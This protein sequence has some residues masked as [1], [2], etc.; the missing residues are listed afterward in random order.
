[1]SRLQ[2]HRDSIP[3][4]QQVIRR[5]L[6]GPLLLP[7][8]WRR[9]SCQDQHQRQSA[10]NGIPLDRLQ[11]IYS[12]ALA[13]HDELRQEV[14]WRD[15]EDLQHRSLGSGFEPGTAALRTE[16]SVYGLCSLYCTGP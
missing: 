8:L 1:M 4:I 3:A 10:V 2:G 6:S 11:E 15:G 14:G 16:A 12:Q 5:R 9:H 7:P 13:S